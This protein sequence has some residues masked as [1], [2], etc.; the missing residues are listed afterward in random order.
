MDGRG[1]SHDV[2]FDFGSSQL[3]DVGYLFQTEEA[4]QSR[5]DVETF[6][7]YVGKKYNIGII[8]L[9]SKGGVGNGS[10]DAYVY[11]ACERSSNYR[12]NKDK[13]SESGVKKLMSRLS[14]DEKIK[15]KEMT[16]AHM[17]P[18]Q[19][20]IS[21]KNENKDNLT[22]MKQMY[23]YRQKI[24]KE[25]MEGRSV[26]QQL[27]SHLS[28]KSYFYSYRD[29]PTTN[30]VTDLF[31]ANKKA[32]QLLYRFYYVLMMDCTYKTNKYKMP[33][34]EIVGCVPTGIFF[35]I[36]MVFLQDEKKIVLNGLFNV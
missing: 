3:E 35:V 14:E 28:K 30:M 1:E 13:G 34:F 10:G 6:V 27:L 9:N 23:N 22:T 2:Y 26:V 17:T 21:I 31:F 25:E 12:K 24:R 8:I 32:V 29:S 19:I 16:R 36:A 11:F 18:S 15:T 20:L 7:R 33:L 4:F 5:Q